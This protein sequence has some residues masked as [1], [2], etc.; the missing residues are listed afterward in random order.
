MRLPSWVL[1]GPGVLVE[2]GR[3]KQPGLLSS[4]KPVPALETVASVTT[5]HKYSCTFMGALAS[6]AAMCETQRLTVSVR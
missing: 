2:P 5:S 3:E 4:D 6:Q 1:P